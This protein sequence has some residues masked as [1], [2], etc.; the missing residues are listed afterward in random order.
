MN[1]VEPC[2]VVPSV[3]P[4]TQAVFPF[5]SDGVIRAS[6]V[7]PLRNREPPPL[8]SRVPTSGSNRW[9]SSRFSHCRE[10]CFGPS[11]EG[12]WRVHPNRLTQPYSEPVVNRRCILH[13]DAV[14]VDCPAEAVRNGVPVDHIHPHR[15]AGLLEG[16]LEAS[17]GS[18]RQR[19]LAHDH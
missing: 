18:T 1:S 11:L 8:N 7:S 14:R 12:A 5:S 15:Q 19:S 9:C 2:P 3:R 6:S 13:N 4:E 10:G 17:E 16:F